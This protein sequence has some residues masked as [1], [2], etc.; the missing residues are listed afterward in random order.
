METS[1]DSPASSGIDVN[2]SMTIRNSMNA[3]DKV[4][5]RPRHGES[6]AVRC[7]WQRRD[8]R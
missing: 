8:W 1:S 7:A 6:M 4:V 5:V 2:R 3:M